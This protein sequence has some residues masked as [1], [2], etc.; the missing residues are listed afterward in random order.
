MMV[1]YIDMT[2]SMCSSANNPSAPAV[3]TVH[4]LQQTA[5]CVVLYTNCNK[6]WHV[7]RC[8]HKLQQ[9]VVCV[10]LYTNYNKLWGVWYCTQTGE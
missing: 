10:V 6:L 5:V 7:L 3:G 2:G 9:S 8:T 4:K 1:C